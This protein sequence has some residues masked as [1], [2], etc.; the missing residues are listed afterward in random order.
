[1]LHKTIG[2]SLQDPRRII[3]VD[4]CLMAFVTA[5]P[6]YECITSFAREVEIMWSNGFRPKSTIVFYL[7]R[8]AMLNMA[9]MNLLGTLKWHAKAPRGNMFTDCRTLFI[10]NSAMGGD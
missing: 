1:M 9:V 2:A 6:I 5:L 7:N 8:F 4:Y 10:C 3:I